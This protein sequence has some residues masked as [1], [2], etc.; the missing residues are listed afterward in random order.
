MNIYLEKKQRGLTYRIISALSA[1]TFIFGSVVP[2]RSSYAQIAPQSVLNLPI[3][4]SRLVQTP[5]FTPTIIRGLTIHPD[6]AL[7]FDFIV[8]K[9]DGPVGAGSKPVLTF[10]QESKKLIKYFLA[11]LT[12]PKDEMWV[13]LSPYEENRIIP[14]GFGDTK[15]GRDMLAQDY[16]LKQ[17][18]ASLMYPEEEL[19]KKFWDRVYTKAA[20]QFGTTEIPVN[21]FN[22]I[23]IVPETASIYEKDQSVFVV[24]SHLKVMLEE[25]YVAM[26]ENMGNKK[27]GLGSVGA[28]LARAFDEDSINRADTRGAAPTNIS[29]AIIRE[30]LIP[31]IEREVNEGEIFANLRQIYNSVI[32]AIWYKEKIIVGAY[33][34]TPLLGQIYIDQNK[35][36]GLD[37]ED[38]QINQKI[39]DQ[40]VEAFKKGVYN[41][42]KEDYDPVTDE[43]IPR[44]YFSGGVSGFGNVKFKSV[45][46]RELV[47]TPLLKTIEDAK[48]ELK[49]VK[50]FLAEH[51]GV[52]PHDVGVANDYDSTLLKTASP[53]AEK[54]EEKMTEWIEKINKLQRSLGIWVERMREDTGDARKREYFQNI[55]DNLEK[56]LIFAKDLKGRLERLKETLEHNDKKGM[57]ASFIE[58]KKSASQAEVLYNLVNN[59][60]NIQ[61]IA[62]RILDFEIKAAEMRYP[63]K[64]EKPIFLTTDQ[65]A[66][67]EVLTADGFDIGE[68]VRAVEVLKKVKNQVVVDTFVDVLLQPDVYN[69]R[70]SRRY[71]D[72]RGALKNALV[73]IKKP[74]VIEVVRR[75][76]EET[77]RKRRNGLLLE[78]FLKFEILSEIFDQVADAEQQNEVYREAVKQDFFSGIKILSESKLADLNSKGEN[79]ERPVSTQEVS[80]ASPIDAVELDEGSPHIK[81]GIN[82]NSDLIDWQVK[83]DGDGVPLPLWDQPIES[84]NI[85]GFVPVIINITP[86]S[87]PIV[88]GLSAED[89]EGHAPFAADD[90]ESDSIPMDLGYMDKYWK[91]ELLG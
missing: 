26:N 83:R 37:T 72:L 48:K 65:K 87:L 57:L 53:V 5:G 2:P 75:Q 88:L 86:V 59:I 21:T 63:F 3:P 50:I 69:Y 46:K 20:E 52:N 49:K 45:K 31:E 79:V 56:E 47:G 34:D 55:K 62:M 77:Y 32:L 78:Q 51:S 44:K 84:M 29:T 19:G 54:I 4:G 74:Y 18:T 13:N 33:G 71:D 27:Y 8:D 91:E 89:L 17:L 22:K 6:N 67:L 64:K 41:Y 23:W 58:K 39:Y 12:V 42:I 28:P 43:I 73:N 81:G 40:Y 14:K 36:K 1:V 24:D 11:G 76:L 90:A 30:I 10:Q 25:D 66:A 15:M 7:A 38:K 85:D 70:R 9:G 61:V 68:K 35:T 16:M 82:F 80:V 60:D